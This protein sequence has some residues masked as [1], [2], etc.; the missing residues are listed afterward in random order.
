M[1][2]L[3]TKLNENENGKFPLCF[4]FIDSTSLFLDTKFQ[5]SSHASMAV[6]TGLCLTWSETK[7]VFSCEGS[8]G[9]LFMY[10]RLLE[11]KPFA[12]L[13]HVRFTP[14][15]ALTKQKHYENLPMQLQIF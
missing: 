9:F 6:Q 8:F 10:M 3:T 14:H 4:R 12:L 15:G 1:K 5:T 7:L 2:S 13:R 11:N